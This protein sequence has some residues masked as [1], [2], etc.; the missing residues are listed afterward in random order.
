MESCTPY[1]NHH[2]LLTVVTASQW[3]KM[4]YTGLSYRVTLME[5]CS[6]VYV[7]G[8]SCHSQWLVNVSQNCFSNA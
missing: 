3:G 8:L 4:R 7:S 5:Y 1:Q 6:S 2:H